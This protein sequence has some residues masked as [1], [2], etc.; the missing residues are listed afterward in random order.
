MEIGVY[1]LGRFGYFWAQLLGQRFSVRAYSRSADRPTPPGVTRVTSLTSL[2]DTDVVFLCPA[3]S[4]MEAVLHEIA[5]L[6]RPRTLIADTCSVKV[7]PSELMKKILPPESQILA[8]HP[9]FGPDSGRNGVQGLPIV[10]HPLQNAQAEFDFWKAAF[11]SMGMKVIELTPDEHDQA[12]AYSQGITHFIGRVL[13]DMGVKPHPI[14]TQGYRSLLEIV[15]Q[16]CND[17]FQLFLDLQRFNPYT[18]AM[19]A[20]LVASLT[21]VQTQLGEA[22]PADGRSKAN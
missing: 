14:A 19:R 10:L 15:Q 16:T 6:T 4:A 13:S 9:M 17:P 8:T 21:K 18:A 12:A 20:D 7:Y 2:M 5:P 1:G 22:G 3:I 11:G